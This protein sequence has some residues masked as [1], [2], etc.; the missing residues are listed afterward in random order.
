MDAREIAQ[1]YSDE[2]Y[3]KFGKRPTEIY[4][5]ERVLGPYEKELG[6]EKIDYIFGMKVKSHTW[7]KY[8]D[9]PP[10]TFFEKLIDIW[11]EIC[12]IF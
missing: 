4:L 3:T 8:S 2:Y 9:I 7:G 5:S 12:C 1:R 10:R 6:A 11:D